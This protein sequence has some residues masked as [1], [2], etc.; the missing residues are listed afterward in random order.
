MLGTVVHT[1]HYRRMEALHWHVG[2]VL[3]QEH[4]AFWRQAERFDPFE[5]IAH[6]RIVVSPKHRS[7][8]GDRPVGASGGS[9]QPRQCGFR[10]PP[11]LLWSLPLTWPRFRR[12][13][14]V[15]VGSLLERML[16]QQLHNVCE[17]A[18]QVEECRVICAT[19]PLLHGRAG[20]RNHG[21]PGCELPGAIYSRQKKLSEEEVDAQ[22]LHF[23]VT[24][25]LQAIVHSMVTFVSN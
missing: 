17:V 22:Y 25:T 15:S 5:A 10:T 7:G 16:Q 21:V 1:H 6:V 8:T 13:G 24:R 4:M 20:R 9:L 18:D 14:S 12:F 19:G 11:W 23:G 3:D 2:D